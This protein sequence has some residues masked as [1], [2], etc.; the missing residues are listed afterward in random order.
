[1]GQVKFR[2]L[3]QSP[4]PSYWLV[5]TRQL[6]FSFGDLVEDAPGLKAPI[7]LAVLYEVVGLEEHK[8]R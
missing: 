2:S 5:C 7:Q 8:E 3:F 4:Y 1:M 6:V